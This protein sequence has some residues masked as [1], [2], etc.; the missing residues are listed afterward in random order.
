MK[1]FT[2]LIFLLLIYLSSNA[3]KFFSEHTIEGYENPII[4]KL[5]KENYKVTFNKD[6]SYYTVLCFVD[7]A[8][9]GRGKASIEIV[10]TKTGDL[11]SKSKEV[12]GQIT[13]FNGYTDPKMLAMQ[14]LADSYLIDLIKKLPRN[15]VKRSPEL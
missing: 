5:V 7:N 14:K 10:D 11:L 2:L 8:G 9:K 4:N 1:S 3:Q 15:S 12:N 13:L 6:S